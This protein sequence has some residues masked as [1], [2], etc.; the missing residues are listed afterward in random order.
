MTT[1]NAMTSKWPA[2]GLALVRLAAGLVFVMHGWRKVQAGPAAVAESFA[3]L[4]LPLPMVSSLLATAA[5]FGGGLL[6][7]A[8]LWTRLAAIPLAFTMLVAMV[9]VH[10][11]QG[12]FLPQG[13]EY[14]L[15]LL[16]VC[17]GL[18]LA[19]G[20][21]PSVDAWLRSTKERGQ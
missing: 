20:G 15:T 2:L 12:F 14:T 17:V 16:A 3:G 21:A 13:Y 4:G 19:G 11:A 18:A 9:T 8:G 5:E 10:L 7:I 1:Y 6:L